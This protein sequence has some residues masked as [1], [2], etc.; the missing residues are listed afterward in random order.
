M[1]SASWPDE[2]HHLSIGSTMTIRRTLTTV[3][4]F[5]VLTA[6]AAGC[7]A[8]Q[9]AD[10][11]P[12]PTTTSTAVVTLNTAALAAKA[13]AAVKSGQSEGRSSQSRGGQGCSREGPRRQ[14]SGSEGRSRTMRRPSRPPRSHNLP[15]P[16]SRNRRSRRPPTLSS[17]KACRSTTTT[18]R[19]HGSSNSSA[20]T[21][22]R[23]PVRCSSSPDAT[24]ATSTPLP[25]PTLD[26][27]RF[28]GAR[29]GASAHPEPPPER[30]HGRRRGSVRRCPYVRRRIRGRR[31]ICAA[32]EIRRRSRDRRPC[33]GAITSFAAPHRCLVGGRRRRP[34]P[35]L[36]GRGACRGRGHARPV[37]TQCR[38]W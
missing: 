9:P 20:W 3:I 17:G 12:A 37:G 18:R 24:R 19:S 10:A 22:N 15:T 4:L 8:A 36:T 13:A 6:G 16:S 29:T 26:S 38:A 35:A 5:A 21:A 23:H 34:S 31:K 27:D 1:R 33:C 32:D 2:L 30:K 14:G 7:S 28:L 11:P 25:A